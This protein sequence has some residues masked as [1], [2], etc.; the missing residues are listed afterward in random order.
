MFNPSIKI[1]PWIQKLAELSKPSTLDKKL[2]ADRGITFQCLEVDKL[3]MVPELIHN[4]WENIDRIRSLYEMIR[5][6]YPG[7]KHFSEKVLEPACVGP[8]M[9][10]PLKL[11]RAVTQYH[12]AQCLMLAIGMV[13]N[14]FLRILN[15]SDYLL[16]EE[17]YRFC[18]DS[19][20]LA[21]RAKARRPLA[22]GH[23]PMSIIAAWLSSDDTAQQAQLRCLI[24]EYEDD[25]AMTQLV[26]QATYLK[27]VIPR[28]VA[29]RLYAFPPSMNEGDEACR[30]VSGEDSGSHTQY[31]A[32]TCSIL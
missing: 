3:G 5:A 6:D 10:L 1:Q 20:T 17:C 7:V 18:A 19:I 16:V 28:G 29:S 23:I 30:D 31:G 24:S 2:A 15:P 4:P 8:P 12:A 32:E 22:A 25:Y 14:G 13:M 26:K 27:Q 11:V 21:E 9:S